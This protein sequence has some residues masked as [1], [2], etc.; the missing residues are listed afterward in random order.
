MRYRFVHVVGL[1]LLCGLWL[2][3]GCGK[4]GPPRKA[5]YPVKG[6][7]T[8]DGAAP[9][10][11]L[12]LTCHNKAGM[13]TKMPTVSQAMSEP[14]GKFSIA[15]YEKGDGVPPGEYT[16]T[17]KWQEFNSMSMSFSGTDKLNN[18][19]ADPE[20]SD[21]TFTVKDAPVDLGEV[22]LTTK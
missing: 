19:Y 17:V 13:D 12:Q 4:S 3:S 15:T 22:K 2:A 9:G 20:K 5:T 18:R 11:S 7:L 1:G 21:I 10:S 6:T 16:L 14:D 8:V